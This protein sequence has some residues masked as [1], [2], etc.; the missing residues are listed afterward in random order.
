MTAG[1]GLLSGAPSLVV[2][3]L[4]FLLRAMGGSVNWTY[5]SVILQARVADAYLGRIFSFDNAANQLATVVGTVVTGAMIQAVGTAQIHI[6]ALVAALTSV[7]P[8]A[9]WVAAV[10]WMERIDRSRQPAPG[11]PEAL[12]VPL[13]GA[14]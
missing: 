10:P 5:S 7:V 13:K 8:L 6:I 2:V 12:A 9:A 4:A 3:A 1:W 11:G 14:D